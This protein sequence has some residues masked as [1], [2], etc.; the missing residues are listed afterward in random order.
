V[1]KTKGALVE[2]ISRPDT[3]ALM[4]EILSFGIDA[5]KRRLILQFLC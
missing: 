1:I 4:L 2:S 5:V 3:E